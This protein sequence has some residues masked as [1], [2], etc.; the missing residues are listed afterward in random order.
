MP[1]GWRIVR[2][3]YAADAFSGEGA[4]LVGGRWNSAGRA[5]VY[6]SEH[7]SLAT[8]EVFAN[9]EPVALR[10]RYVVIGAQWEEAITERARVADLPRNWREFPA[11]MATA[12]FGDRWLRDARSAVLAIPSVII[13]AETNYLLNPAHPD[14]HRI[15]IGEPQPYEFDPRLLRH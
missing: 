13:P 9:V 7:Q 3:R 15:R 14:F 8:L 1:S 12:A 6:L 2:A 5:V 4:R 10:A 11:G